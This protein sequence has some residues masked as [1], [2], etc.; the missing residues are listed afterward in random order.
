MAVSIKNS[1]SVAAE[2]SVKVYK[3]DYQQEMDNILKDVRKRA[4]LPG[5]RKG[6]VPKSFIEKRYGMSAKLDAINKFVGTQV[7]EYIQQEQLRILG[8]P[9]PVDGQNVADLEENEEFEFNFEVA[10]APEIDVKLDK[11]LT[12]PYYNIEIGDNLVD[13]HIEQM[14]NQY[15]RRVEVDIIEEKDLVRGTLTEFEDG[16]PK[17]GGLVN[18]NAMLLPQYIKDEES[19]TKFV[20]AKKETS[21]IFEPFKAYEGNTA[22]L[23]S[24]LNISKEEITKYEG[25]EFSFQVSSIS[26]HEAA[27]LNEEFFTTAFGAEADIKDEAS[28]RDHIKESLQEQ[29]TPE[30]DYMF[31]TD[32]RKAILEKAGKVELA[33]SI[34]KRWLKQSNKDNND[35]QL[36]KDFPLMVKDLTY[37]LVKDSVLAEHKVEITQE[38]ELTFAIVVA[39]RQFAQYGMS[40]VPNDVLEGYAKQLLAKEDSAK[41]IKA[42]L[43][44]NKFATIVKELVTLDLKSVTPEEFG[45]LSQGAH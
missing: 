8:E 37:Q 44:D 45:N 12:I 7:F 17:D 27:Q 38:E 43:I 35:E 21:I 28:L 14:L 9:V 29:F 4:E 6:H 23:S 19:R 34:L 39:K 15:G 3:A 20:G 16:K 33:E 41:G 25:T 32:T 13:S 36:E 42:R 24:F 2:I 18:D 40:S 30:S 22:E 1:S 10:L 31:I 26:R 11:K 5:F